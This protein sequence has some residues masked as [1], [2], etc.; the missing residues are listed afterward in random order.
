MTCHTQP[1]GVRPLVHGSVA[2][3][4]PAVSATMRG[5]PPRIVS[6]PESTSSG[7]L[8]VNVTVP[9]WGLPNMSR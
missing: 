7:V 9:D 5:A 2:L 4:L 8:G 6:D 1:G 3:T